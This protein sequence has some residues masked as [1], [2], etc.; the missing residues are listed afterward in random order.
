MFVVGKDRDPRRE[1]EAFTSQCF[2]KP[3]HSSPGLKE[4]VQV[5][6]H[7]SKALHQFPKV[8]PMAEKRLT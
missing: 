4:R 1:N 8:N 5:P 7:L 6:L 3:D 2:S